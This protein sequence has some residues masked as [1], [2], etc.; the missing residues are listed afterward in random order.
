MIGLIFSNLRKRS[1]KL[2]YNWFDILC[3]EIIY[4][5][6]SLYSMKLDKSD[7][8]NYFGYFQVFVFYCYSVFF[9]GFLRQVWG[10]IY[11]LM[12]SEQLVGRGQARVG[13]RVVGGGKVY[14]VGR[15]GKI[16]VVWR[17]FSGYL[18]WRFFVVY[19]VV[20]GREF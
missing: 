3:K 6:N 1:W 4:D 12:L 8:I 7:S 9:Q 16:V 15:Y 5:F 17:L 14:L 10:Q 19:F 20:F 18:L 13:E 2:V 11:L